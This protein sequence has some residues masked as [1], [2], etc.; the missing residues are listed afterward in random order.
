MSRPTPAST[1]A[2]NRSAIASR[3]VLQVIHTAGP[4]GAETVVLNLAAGLNERRWRSLVTLPSMDWLGGALSDAGI[5]PRII[6]DRKRLSYLRGIVSLL[7]TER[8]D[9]LHA[10]LLGPASYAAVAAMACRVPLVITFHGHLDITPPSAF[11]TARFALI[12]GAHPTVVLVSEPLRTALL[13]TGRI[14]GSCTT[15]IPNGIDT[16]VFRPAADTGFRAEL[17]LPADAIVVG[18]IGNLRPAKDYP[19]FLRA[20]AILARQSPRYR[21]VIV[22]QGGD[23][24]LGQLLRLRSE[25]A[26]DDRVVFA[27]FRSDVPRALNAF[28]TLVLSSSSEGFSL[29]TIQA[30]ACGVPVIATRCGGPEQI[31]SHE[32]DGILVATGDAAAIA[33]AVQRLSSEPALRERLAA[34]ARRTV[35]STYSLDSMLGR[36]E[37]LYSNLL[38]GPAEPGSSAGGDRA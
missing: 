11:E 13:D 23:P 34:N 38:R 35:E 4:G 9:I 29:A 24:L 25:L 37:A 19:T 6:P 17:G 36:Y 14:P 3:T 18:A 33:A 32:L 31:L 8:V 27:G 16:T 21:F 30:M 1:R 20:A 12:R 15:V 2:G 7:R 28:D 10:H 26:L 5:A 22:G